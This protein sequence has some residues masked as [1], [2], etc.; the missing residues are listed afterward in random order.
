MKFKTLTSAFEVNIAGKTIRRVPDN[1]SG[2]WKSYVS[3]SKPKIGSPVLVVWSEDNFGN[4]TKSTLTS[5][6]VSFE[7]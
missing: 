3:I 5:P 7:Y 4:S 6:V 1:I 2:C